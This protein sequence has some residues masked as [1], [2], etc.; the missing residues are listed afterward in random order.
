MVFITFSAMNFQGWNVTRST[1]LQNSTVSVHGRIA[2][3]T[4]TYLW[5]AGPP[6]RCRAIGPDSAAI[7][8]ATPM[9]VTSRYTSEVL[10]MRTR[11]ARSGS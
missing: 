10:T 8:A 2:A 5:Y 3:P 6:T 7:T 1:S 11:A 9:P 4:S